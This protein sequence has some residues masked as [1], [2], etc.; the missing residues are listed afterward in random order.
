[1]RDAV[2]Y[3][4]ER[5]TGDAGFASSALASVS[6]PA[7]T[8]RAIQAL[9]AAG[10]DLFSS[11]WRRCVNTPFDAL[12]DAQV[13]DGSFESGLEVT[14]AAVPGLM[15]R[16]M[17]LQGRYLAALK[18][19]EWLHTRQLDDGGF[20]N[21]GVTADAIYAIALCGQDPAGSQW[22][23]PV[24]GKT[25]LDALDSQT[26]A[27]YI[28]GAP[29]GGPAGELA[30]LI[31]ALHQAGQN[32]YNFRSMDLVGDLKDLCDDYS[33]KCHPYKVFSHGLA[34]IA[35]RAV[36]E[37]IPPEAVATIEDEQLAEGGWP[38]AWGATTADV[39]SSGLSM[40][41]IVAGEGLSSPDI[42][43]D[44]AA[45]LQS[46]R[47]PGGAYPD[48]ATRSEP[49]CNSTS[50]AIEGLLAS[51]RHREQPLIIP[52]DT[53]GMLSSWDALLGFQ[54]PSG[55]FAFTASGPESRLLATLEAIRAL[56]SALYPDYEPMAE[57]RTITGT[58]YARL[59]CGDGL[60][61]VAPLSGD[62]NNDGSASLS[63]RVEDETWRSSSS[64]MSKTGIAYLLRP[65]LEAGADYEIQLTYSD[66]DGVSGE[67][68]QYL[69]VHEGKACIPLT[70][71][72]YS[73]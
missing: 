27:D 22:E 23:H 6:D 42:S 41:A 12:L 7:S 25:P 11:K 61:I 69:T 65:H 57:D 14:A 62:K 33:P 43:E 53:G 19:L 44:F 50:L 36:S 29:P 10:E 54:E 28:A 32:P 1:V 5:Q 24:T 47:F 52:L 45:F 59:T 8:S 55:S 73:G 60:E 71:R 20:G 30:K 9:L 63:Y 17:P 38:W 56:V 70:L 15:G 18:A 13:G 21:G 39:D 34:L 35:L 3:L 64:P 58:A 51:G 68:T 4:E 40:Q 26:I 37:T 66:P 48:L 67:G 72:T 31:R 16:S 2:L 46:V 49:N